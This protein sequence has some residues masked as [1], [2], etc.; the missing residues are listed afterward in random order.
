MFQD[1]EQTIQSVSTALEL[2]FPRKYSNWQSSIDDFLSPQL[3]NHHIQESATESFPPVIIDSISAFQ[4]I[5]NQTANQNKYQDQ[6]DEYLKS[7][8][9]LV[10]LF[11]H[12]DLLLER[13]QIPSKTEA[14]LFFGSQNAFEEEKSQIRAIFG[15]EQKLSF[16]LSNH[17]T[18]D[19]L[20]L[21]PASEACIIQLVS[22]T[23]QYQDQS[24]WDLI[25]VR[26]NAV[27]KQEDRFSFFTVDPHIIFGL[28]SCE[29]KAISCQFHYIILPI[30][31]QVMNQQIASAYELQTQTLAQ[32]AGQIYLLEKDKEGLTANL[33]HVQALLAESH[34][35][36]QDLGKALAAQQTENEAILKS[37]TF[38]L[39]KGILSPLQLLLTIFQKNKK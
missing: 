28:P 5:N 15:T 9:Q 27:K 31:R 10:D 36:E 30:S 18:F 2:D 22:A 8:Q 21:D 13:F 3:R 14:Q 32:Q 37:L 23:V 17:E 25:F 6:L 38:R 11:Y 4:S 19:A 34:K 20:R 35:K 16:T 33:K 7:F 29:Q 1:L 24:K 39:G 12:H 26:S